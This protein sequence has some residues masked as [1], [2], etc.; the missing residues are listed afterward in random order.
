MPSMPSPTSTSSSNRSKL[1]DDDSAS[2]RWMQQQQQHGLSLGG[3]SQ[4]ATNART[5]EHLNPAGD[6]YT[7]GGTYYIPSG[8]DG[9]VNSRKGE[10]SPII[11]GN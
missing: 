7:A 4:G 2:K 5:G 11:P 8:P 10:Y 1:W 9:V 6:G 3:D